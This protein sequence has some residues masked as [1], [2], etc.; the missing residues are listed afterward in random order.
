MADKSSDEQPKQVIAK[1]VVTPKRKYFSPTQGEVDADTLE[2]AA[3][4][5]EAKL[6]N[7]NTKDTKVGDA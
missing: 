1:Q 7:T 6:A 2:E 3:Q 4:L 5:V